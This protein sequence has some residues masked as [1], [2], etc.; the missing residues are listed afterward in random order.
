MIKKFLFAVFMASLMFTVQISFIG[1]EDN[2]D[3][4][5][6][7]VSGSADQFPATNNYEVNARIVGV[8]SFGGL[9]HVLIFRSLKMEQLLKTHLF[10]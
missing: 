3:D 4:S 10:W 6:P 7:D 1:C 5:G 9:I 8:V 2:N